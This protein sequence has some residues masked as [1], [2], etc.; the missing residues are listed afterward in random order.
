MIA[1]ALLTLQTAPS[2]SDTYRHQQHQQP[3]SINSSLS[4]TF[5]Q[6]WKNLGFKIFLG[7]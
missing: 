3:G 4:I 1:V 7:F 5:Y 6:G 2:A